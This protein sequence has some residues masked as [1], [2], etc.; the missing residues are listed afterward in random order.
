MKITVKINDSSY[1][2][3]VG[4]INARP[5]QATLN[6]ETFEVWPEESVLESIAPALITTTEKPGPAPATRSN[7]APQSGGDTSKAISAPIPGVIISVSAKVGD[8]ISPGQEVCILEAMKMKNSI[9]ST[10]TGKI[11]TVR[12]NPGDH[13]QHGQILFEFSN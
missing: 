5:I 4:D 2:V 9:K 8:N 12:I 10:R 13:V 6:G 7:P 3:E 11:S 1:D